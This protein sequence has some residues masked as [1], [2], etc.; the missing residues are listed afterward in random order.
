MQ[1]SMLKNDAL[2]FKN[3]IIYEVPVRAFADSNGDGIGDFPGLTEKLDYLQD[4]GVTALWVLPFFPSPL[5]DDGYDIAEYTTV[6]PIY[7]TLED[8]Q[9]FLAAAHQRGIRVIIELIVNHTS[10]QHPWFQRARRALKGSP[11]R[12]FYVWSDT[13][14]KY[15]EARIIFQD[16]ETSNWAWDAVAKAYYWHRFY[17]HQPDLNYE[18]PAVRQAV[19]D[20]LDFW[21]GMGVDG[22]RLDAVPYL[23]EQEGTNCENLPQTHAFLKELRS[24][25]DAKFP[26]RMLLAEANQWPEDAAQYYGD[27]DECQM[28]FHFPLMPRLFMAL[29]MEDNFPIADILQQT[30]SIPDNCQWALFLRNHDELTLEMVTDEDRDFMYRVYAQDPVMRVNLGIRRRLAP[31]LGNDRRQIELLNS[32]LLSLPGTPVLYYGD[33]IGMGDNVY[34]GDRNGVR[35][36]MHWSSDRNAGFSRANPQKLYLPV[37]VDSEYHYEAVNVEAQRANPNSLWYAM[38]RLIA[39]RRRFQAFG[40]GSFELLHSTNRKVL[41]Y[42]RIHEEEHILVVANLSHFVQTVELDLSAFK[43]ITPIEIFGHTE[44][45]LIGESPYFLSL[46]P[47]G[48]YWFTLSR[49]PSLTQPSK[50]QAE[51]P[52]LVVREQWQNVFS[53]RESKATLEFI[54][55]DYLYTCDWFGG[56]N[57]TIQTA[58]IN[59]VISISGERVP[60]RETR[61]T[62]VETTRRVWGQGENFPFSPTGEQSPGSGNP[63]AALTHLSPFPISHSLIMLQVEYIQGDL[64]TYLLLLSYAE[65]EQAMHLLTETPQAAIARVQ[66]SG[67]GG[68]GRQG[69]QRGI[70]EESPFLSPHSPTPPLPHSPTP[71][72]PHSPG[73][74]FDAV[75]D[76][77][78]LSLLVNAISHNA[79]YQGITGELIASNTDLFSQLNPQA[80]QLEPTLLKGEHRST[81]V[82]YSDRFLLKLFRKV[83]EGIHPDLEIRRFLNEKKHAKHF[84]GVAGVLEYHRHRQRNASPTSVTLGI[85]QE[86]IPDTRNGWDY[87]LDSLQG[88]FEHVRTQ[89][90][91]I[92]DVPMTTSSLLDLPFVEIPELVSQTIHSYLI[93]AQLLGECTAEFHIALAG[94]RQNPDFAPEPFSTFY[95]RSIYQYARNLTG[96]VFLLLQ[97]KLNSL[98][99]DTQQLA[100][101]VLERQ[102][103]ILGRFQLVL[104]QKIT[105]MRTRY[106]GDYH[107]GQVLYTGKDFIIID[108]EGKV[109][110]NLNERRMKRSPLRDVAGMLLSFHYAV[111][112]ALRTEIESGM[113]S[114][115]D[116]PQIAAWANFWYTWVSAAFLNSYLKTAAG[117]NFLP[118]TTAELR[119]L[120]NAYVLEKAI[121]ALGDE[122]KN[123]PDSVEIPLQKI[124]QLL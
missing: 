3:A 56:K 120:L 121:Y 46:S 67:Q 32:L 58:R 41:A 60:D 27:G 39:T 99:S 76:Q 122:L 54:L 48:F 21:L 86:F 64:E 119:V 81:L 97:D 89:Q 42:K 77:N 106:H 73:V 93:N 18:N 53:Q 24:H 5:K 118:Q 68:Q 101:A 49:K 62:G 94:D 83:E 8:F 103:E 11:E 66:M 55:R 115:V 75:A 2:W 84:A 71:P 23:Y 78:F 107:L 17:S 85:L 30:P 52:T 74:L 44:F 1:N 70:I 110:R 114:S 82:V 79:S 117:S 113:I 124:L 69:G 80:T 95:Q 98:P 90:A 111:S 92:T 108:F 43:G 123:R 105:A 35:T 59:E 112:Q 36:P 14:E 61:T 9:E 25:I 13:P 16:F 96:Q 40:Q 7:G 38:K 6:N 26:N 100:K 10:D 72:L 19:F 88:F 50:P 15:Q 102:Q 29:R 104:N 31:L 63:P 109:T 34:V 65:G 91:N 87:T 33:E 4:L 20:V 12:D 37:I 47:Y 57:R 116:L 22:L 45:P 51:L 28:N